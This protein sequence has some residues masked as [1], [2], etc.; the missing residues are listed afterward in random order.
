MFYNPSSD[1]SA[2]L[3]QMFIMCH[4]IPRQSQRQKFLPQ[5]QMIRHMPEPLRFQSQIFLFIGHKKSLLIQAGC[6]DQPLMFGI[7]NPDTPL[8]Q[9][10][11]NT[12]RYDSKNIR[13][14]IVHD[15]ILFPQRHAFFIKGNLNGKWLIQHI[16]LYCVY[17]PLKGQIL[18]I[19]RP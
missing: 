18:C 8:H 10:I 15:M 5:M 3:H 17:Q 2:Q 4:I 6:P 11:H 13:E 14:R 16:V 19:F 1:Q 7:I 12:N 9:F